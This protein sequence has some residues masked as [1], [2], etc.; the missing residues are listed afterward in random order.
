M[1]RI[2]APRDLDKAVRSR[3]VRLNAIA[4][5][6]TVGIVAGLGLFVAT[7]W[8]ILKGGPDVGK[9][10]NLLGHY[11]IGYRVTFVGSLIGLAY[12]FFTGFSGAFLFAKIYNWIAGIRAGSEPKGFEES[13]KKL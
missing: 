2:E 13:T 10:L 5:A 3:V 1:S 7:N 12:G 6:L 9:H 4:Q 8:L 11:F